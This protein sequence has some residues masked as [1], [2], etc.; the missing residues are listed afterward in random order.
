MENK[1]NYLEKE[2]EKNDKPTVEKTEN[3]ISAGTHMGQRLERLAR[4]TISSTYGHGY[5][6]IGL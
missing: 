1:I 5:F 6:G 2:L 4:K 3:Y